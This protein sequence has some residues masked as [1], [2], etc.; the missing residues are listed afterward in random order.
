MEKMVIKMNVFL[1]SYGCGQEAKYQIG[2]KKRWCCSEYWQ[3]C[4]RMRKKNSVSLLGEK[5][6]MFEKKRPEVSE[7]MKNGGAAY[8][9][10]FVTKEGRRRQLEWMKN[11]GAAYLRSF[12]KNISFPQTAI[13]ENV[14]ILFPDLT[15]IIN[16]PFLNYSLDVVILE[17]KIVVEYDGFPFHDDSIFGDTKKD[18]E[19]QKECEK[20]GW[21]FIRYK[22]TRAKDI[23]PTSEQVKEDIKEVLTCLN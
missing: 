2:K 11:G 6:P 21:K 14:K 1:C 5:N 22:G 8:V 17:F 12:V 13:Y 15:V 19:R 18:L 16:Y 10:S 20:Y 7:W 4:P 23:I 3:S 9:N